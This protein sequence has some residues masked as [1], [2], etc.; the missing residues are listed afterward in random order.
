MDHSI[1]AGDDV[2][3]QHVFCPWWPWSLTFDLDIQTHPRG[4]PNTS[5]LWI[6]CKS[7]QHFPR[8][9][10]HKQKKLEAKDVL[11]NINRTLA[12]MWVTLLPCCRFTPITPRQ[13][14]NGPI[15]CCV[16]L[17]AASAYHWYHSNKKTKSQ[18]ALKT[19]P[20]AV[21]HTV[22][23]YVKLLNL[24]KQNLQCCRNYFNVNEDL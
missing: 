7:V 6:W 20:Y 9:L 22:T 8:Y 21:H 1:A 12:A 24:I 17:F 4:E 14:W 10:I 15:C 23:S 5:S 11:P 16:T 19:E 18:T 13:Q 3:A 2:S